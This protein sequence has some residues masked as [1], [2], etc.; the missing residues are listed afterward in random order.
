M[1]SESKFGP[2]ERKNSP[3]EHYCEMIAQEL[4]EDVL[5]PGDVFHLQLAGERCSKSFAEAKGDREKELKLM[6]DWASK[7]FLPTGPEGFL[8]PGKCT[9]RTLYLFTES[10]CEW[11]HEAT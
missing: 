11:K 9:C 2:S 3:Q 4:S 10:V 5:T 1:F 8:P 7:G 6:L